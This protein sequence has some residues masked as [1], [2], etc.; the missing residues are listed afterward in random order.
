MQM[1]THLQELV[2]DLYQHWVQPCTAVEAEYWHQRLLLV[3]ADDDDTEQ[4]RATEW[5]R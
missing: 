4:Q 5:T 1:L 3:K 2:V